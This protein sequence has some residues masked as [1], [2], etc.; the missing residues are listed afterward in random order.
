[1]IYS[2]VVDAVTSR[3][4][5]VP[6]GDN[7]TIQS[8]EIISVCQRVINIVGSAHLAALSLGCRTEILLFFSCFTVFLNSEVL[9][10]SSGG[11]ASTSG[12]GL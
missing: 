4:F 6:Q 2:I 7:D 5:L 9:K 11:I 8:L 1:M 12:L 10:D 3:N